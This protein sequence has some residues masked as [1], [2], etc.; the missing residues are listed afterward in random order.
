MG[1]FYLLYKRNYIALENHRVWYIITGR[2]IEAQAYKDKLSININ[3]RM[4]IYKCDISEC[5]Y[6]KESLGLHF[7]INENVCECLVWMRM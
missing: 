5:E 4:F 2:A 3:F 7:G 1:L 6:R